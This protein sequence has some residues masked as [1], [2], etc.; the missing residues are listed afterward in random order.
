MLAQ[1]EV[2]IAELIWCHMQPGV[3]GGIG[4]VVIGGRI[5]NLGTAE[6]VIPLTDVIGAEAQ[7]ERQLPRS[8]PG[9]LCPD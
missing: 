4:T 2:G 1:P 6:L 3:G 5:P 8:F 7:I 9:I